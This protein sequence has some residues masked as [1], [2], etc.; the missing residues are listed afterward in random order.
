M[1]ATVSDSDRRLALRAQAARI[2][3]YLPDLLEQRA[4]VEVRLADL[5]ALVKEERAAMTSLMDE[6]DQLD[7]KRCGRCRERKALNEF[8][9]N[10]AQAD[11]FD[12]YCRGCRKAYRLEAR[13]AAA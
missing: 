9:K 2:R 12:G 6:A 5:E 1:P 8:N 11:G 3:S 7:A 13:T 4:V 10:A